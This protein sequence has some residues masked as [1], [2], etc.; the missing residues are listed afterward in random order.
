MYCR[1]QISCMGMTWICQLSHGIVYP[2]LSLTCGKHWGKYEFSSQLGLYSRELSTAHSDTSKVK[3]NKKSGEKLQISG[4]AF[5]QVKKRQHMVISHFGRKE[6]WA[7]S[8]HLPIAMFVEVNCQLRHL[9]WFILSF[10]FGTLCH[11]H[12]HWSCWNLFATE[13]INAEECSV[14]NMEQHEEC[15]RCVR[16]IFSY[17]SS[18]TLYPC[19]GS[20]TEFSV[21]SIWALPVRGGGSWPLPEW[22]GAIFCRTPTGPT[23]KRQSCSW[24]C[25]C[26]C[27]S[28]SWRR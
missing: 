15:F 21:T 13:D 12:F 17:A 8:P 25:S 22:F 20:P 16:N 23:Q 19:Q 11:P 4:L 27:C 24:S 3:F 7:T 1:W 6:F 5:I 9:K 14:K 28:C 18:S 2:C 10:V 26:C